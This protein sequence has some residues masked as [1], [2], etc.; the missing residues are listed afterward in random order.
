[1]GLLSGLARGGARGVERGGFHV[2]GDILGN[3]LQAAERAPSR[4]ALTAGAGAAGEAGAAAAR[5]EETAL[6]STVRPVTHPPQP[7]VHVNAS[8]QGEAKWI[9]GG[10]VATSALTVGGGIYA[11]NL[12][13]GDVAD[14][15]SAINKGMSDLG[16][17]MGNV[18]KDTK[19]CLLYTS[20]AADE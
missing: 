10:T 1:M 16:N 6:A 8:K 7:S 18:G 13:R 4:G 15:A 11:H 3:A 17:K 5:A 20:D 14:T 12:A 2:A 9:A 19:D